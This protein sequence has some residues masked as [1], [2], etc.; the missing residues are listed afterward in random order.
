MN[1]LKYFFLAAALINLNFS[2]LFAQHSSK[3]DVKTED[4]LNKFN[5]SYIKSMM[6][7]KAQIVQDY[8]AENIRLMPE[9]QKT[10]IG[11]NNAL[12]YHNAFT[13]RFDIL[14][15]N[16]DKIEILDLGT[17]VVELG[18]FNISMKLKSTGKEYELKGKYQNFWAKQENSKLSLITMTWNYSHQ[19]EFAEQLRF[20]QVKIVNIAFEPHIPINNS[21]SFE[22]AALNRLSELT[23]TQH[24]DKIWS[25][26]Y[27][28]DAKLIYSNHPIY[29]G[30]KAVSEFLKDHVTHLPVF[31]KLDIRNDKIDN[32]GEYV[33]EYA[34]HIAI[35]RNGDWSGVNTGKNVT[36][37]RREKNCSLKIFRG[38]AMYD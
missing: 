8:Y 23:I 36:I 37:W 10:I 3:T 29:E 31:E 12:S 18:M 15:Y 7:K 21:I 24:D 26:F 38:M 11:K 33:V 16:I 6:D 28:D 5:S 9:Y 2:G 35:I 22:L 25:Q 20:D 34:S 13:A 1:K 32:L 19:V 27:T 30:K 4:F 14:K 17:Q